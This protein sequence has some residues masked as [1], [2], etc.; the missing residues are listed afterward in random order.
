MG[1]SREIGVAQ[2]GPTRLGPSPLLHSQGGGSPHDTSGSG[3]LG[4]GLGRMLGLGLAQLGLAW[5]RLRL[6]SAWL[7]WFHIIFNISG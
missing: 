4:S 6:G 5:L 1:S 7:G 3:W 2:T